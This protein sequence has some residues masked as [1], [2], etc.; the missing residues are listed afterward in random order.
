MIYQGS[1]TL[2]TI[3]CDKDLTNVQDIKVLIYSKRKKL[4]ELVKQDIQIN[5]NIVSFILTQQDTLSFEVGIVNIEL[6]YLDSNGLIE[7]SDIK[8]MSVEARRD[9]RLLD[10]TVIGNP[11]T[12]T[13]DIDMTGNIIIYQGGS[14][15]GIDRAE[16]ERII[17]EYF[18]LHKG[19]L[20]GEPGEPGYTPIRGTDYWT[21]ED[22]AEIQSYIDTQIGGALDG[23]Y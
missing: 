4:K 22:I 9:S 17:A 3:K 1:Q 5:R 8:T 7:L 14:G 19:E 20:I 12:D 10:G 13:F 6:K 23:S 11:I 15:S 16:C 21:A 18:T 2:I